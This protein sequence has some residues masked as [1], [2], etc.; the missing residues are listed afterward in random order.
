MLGLCNL[1]IVVGRMKSEAHQCP[2]V[3]GLDPPS[4][5]ESKVHH[6]GLERV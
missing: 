2:N 1:G 4:L 5:Y 6:S 3:D